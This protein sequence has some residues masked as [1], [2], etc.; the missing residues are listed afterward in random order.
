[1]RGGEGEPDAVKTVQTSHGLPTN[2]SW[3]RLLIFSKCRNDPLIYENILHFHRHLM[4]HCTSGG[5]WASICSYQ[6]FSISATPLIY[7]IAYNGLSIGNFRLQ[8]AEAEALAFTANNGPRLRCIRTISWI[9]FII[10]IKSGMLKA[11]KG[12]FG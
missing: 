2:I 5:K 12:S 11:S 1:M 9:I 6:H 4:M 10:D 7:E 3:T 8:I